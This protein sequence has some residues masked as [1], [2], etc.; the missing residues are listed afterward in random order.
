MAKIRDYLVELLGRAFDIREGEMRRAVLMQLNI[1]LIIST[2][3]IVKPTVNGLFLAKFGAESLPRAFILVAIFAGL[4]SILYARALN[5]VSLD[6]IIHITLRSSV[7]T[8]VAFGFFLRLN[9]LESWVL[10]LFYLWVSIFAVLSASQFWVLANM[11]FNTRE[12]KRLFGFIGAGAIAGGIFGGYLTSLLAPTLGSEN[13]PFVSAF[14]LAFC[15]PIT[16]HVWQRDVTAAPAPMVKKEKRGKQLAPSPLR[17]IRSS[18]HLSLLAGIV[19]I[20]VVVAKLVDYQFSDL[21]ALHIPDR[22]DLTAFFGFWFSSFNLISLFLQL[23]LTRRVVGML[24]VGTSLFFLP[25][26]IFLAAAA[27]VFFPELWVAVILKLADGSLKQSINKAA[28]ELLILPIPQEVKNQTKTFIDVFVDSLATG[29]SGLIL[30]FVVSGL[31]LSTRAISIIILVLIL[32]WGWLALQ[33]RGEYIRTF[34]KRIDQ[35]QEVNNRQMLDLSQESV[36]SG[37]KKVLDQGAEKQIL[38][39]LE[40]IR[41]A[42]DDRFFDNVLPLLQHSSSS[43]RAKAIHYLYYLKK[44]SIPEEIEPLTHDESQKVKI[45]AFEYLIEHRP[46]D[47]VELIT[48]YLNDGDYRIYGAALVSLAYETRDNLTLRRDF[49]LEYRLQDTL[50]RIPE[51]EDPDKARFM[52]VTALKVIAYSHLKEH[53]SVIAASLEEENAEEVRKQAVLSAGYTHDVS[54]IP[55]LIEFLG[56]KQYAPAANDALL[57]FGNLA[58]PALAQKMAD[59]ESSI[60]LRRTIPNLVKKMGTQEAVDFLFARFDYPDQ[61]IRFEV[62]RGLNYLNTNFAH[63]K[64]QRKQIMQSILEEAR[65]YS[66][67]LAILYAQN[68]RQIPG[69]ESFS[70]QMALAEGR[71]SLIRLLEGRLDRN[72]ERIFRLL[73]LQYPPDDIF[74]I[75]KGIQSKQSDL[76]NDALEFLDNLLEANL[77]KVLIPLVETAMMDTFSEKAIKHLKLKIPGEYECFSRLLSGKDTRIALAVLYIIQQL[78]DPKYIP[79]VKMGIENPQEKIRDYALRTLEMLQN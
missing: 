64:F 36:V 35:A 7:I 66:D 47:R 46:A 34:K 16:S 40:K 41:E 55:R 56:D 18:K 74:S 4:V 65:L 26:S 72:L 11:V 15:I 19:G 22:D 44:N 49:G 73:G 38:Y 10:Y 71:S 67:T 37:L 33:I 24:G 69:E 53:Y 20:S 42:Q 28:V 29:I 70:R 51:E 30:I 68:Q 23:F 31:D 9:F 8:L 17:Q 12:A 32:L 3:L 54:F 39:V 43:V 76:R 79:L 1:F 60:E 57:H 27:L 59:Q 61:V 25:G 14:L 78:D 52:Q 6:R 5:R 50:T 45:K 48:R 21:A 58:L 13:L 77:K 75:Y 63:L 62:L 2:L